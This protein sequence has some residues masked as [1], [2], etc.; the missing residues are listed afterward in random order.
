[1]ASAAGLKT[2]AKIEKAG[3]GYQPAPGKLLRVRAAPGTRLEKSMG[4]AADA[5]EASASG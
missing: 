5:Y 4:G 2:L 3:K 1:M